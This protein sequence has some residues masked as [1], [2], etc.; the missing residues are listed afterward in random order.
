M[1]SILKL[2]IHLFAL[3]WFIE[4][5]VIA[6]RLGVAIDRPFRLTNMRYIDKVKIKISLI[7][8]HC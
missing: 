1:M 4:C 6:I 7:I 8:H 3:S 5:T 2:L